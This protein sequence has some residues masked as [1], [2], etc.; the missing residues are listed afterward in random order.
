MFGALKSLQDVTR[1]KFGQ[2]GVD[3]ITN[4]PHLV[5]AQIDETLYM[6]E[7]GTARPARTFSIH[8]VSDNTTFRTGVSGREPIMGVG[9]NG[10]YDGR[11]GFPCGP[12]FMPSGMGMPGF[13]PGPGG[14]NL[15]LI[16]G[17]VAVVAIIAFF[18]LR[19]K[20]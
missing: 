15:P 1:K 10:S 9:C 6:K 20:K 2:P 17:G 12:V 18:A 11:T 8:K 3:A 14:S 4:Y 16:I 13:A 5:R 7:E 19:G